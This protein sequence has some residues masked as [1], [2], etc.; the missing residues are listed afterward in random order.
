[1]ALVLENLETEDLLTV[2]MERDVADQ[3]WPRVQ[4]WG[5]LRPDPERLLIQV[6]REHLADLLRA[7]GTP[8]LSALPPD[9]EPIPLTLKE[10]VRLQMA[11]EPFILGLLENQKVIAVPGVVG[12]IAEHTRSLKV[13]DKI[14]RCH[15]L[16][17]GVNKDVPRL[18][19]GNPSRIP[20]NRIRSFVHVRFVSKTD[21]QRLLRPG[22]G[23]RPEVR[24]EIASYLEDLKQ[25]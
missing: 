20:T 18:L 22:T 14:L 16:F 3:L 25:G 9:Q 4:S 7:D 5:A 2:R 19:L 15:D 12:L 1:M 21:L 6:R 24:K 11:N 8:L 10:M 23:I 13:L 17:T